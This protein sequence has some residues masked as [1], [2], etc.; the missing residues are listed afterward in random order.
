MLLGEFTAFWK[1][2]NFLWR[3]VRRNVLR[4]KKR[5]LITSVGVMFGTAILVM[6]FGMKDTV[7]SLI[8]SQYETIQ[9]YDMRVNMSAFIPERD[10][11][12]FAS[13]EHVTYME[14]LLE[15]GVEIKNGGTEKMIGLT[16]MVPNAKLYRLSDQEGQVVSLT[17]RGILMPEKLA[18]QLS[19]ETGRPMTVRPLISGKSAKESFLAREVY[20]YVGMSAFCSFEEAGAILGEGTV[21][22]AFVLKL[23]HP[24]NAEA[25][26][27]IL[28]DY[29]SVNS[30]TTKLDAFNN[31]AKN[32]EL[33]AAF[34]SVVNFFAGF[35]SIAFI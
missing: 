7:D 13:L 17:P 26:R 1:R 30:V 34:L 6:T 19:L 4:H 8:R 23:D 20:Q 2:L 12:T 22:N 31:L 5:N 32:K 29:G 25:V 11:K 28:K 27:N 10:W 16:A 33:I 24:E 35:L 15:L 14:P 9:N 21:A 18:R 3:M